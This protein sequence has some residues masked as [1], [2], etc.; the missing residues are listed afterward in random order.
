MAFSCCLHCT[1]SILV[2]AFLLATASSPYLWPLPDT[3]PPQLHD[4][5]CC[6]RPQDMPLVDGPQQRASGGL[7]PQPVMTGPP[8]GRPLPMPGSPSQPM[9]VNLDIPDHTRM[10]LRPGQLVLNL[11]KRPG[12]EGGSPGRRPDAG[13][14]LQHDDAGPLPP[15][16]L[17]NAAGIPVGQLPSNFMPI[18]K[19][20]AACLGSPVCVCGLTAELAGC[21][22]TWYAASVLFAVLAKPRACCGLSLR[23]LWEVSCMVSTCGMAH[24]SSAASHACCALYCCRQPRRAGQ[25]PR[26]RP[27]GRHPP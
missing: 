19:L 11:S 26:A 3:T 16:R 15:K 4:M 17:K 9:A 6:L 10:N 22:C 20:R 1:A 12:P 5:L 27:A 21:M 18:S 25:L 14:M 2:K 23:Q 24:F 7:H 8:L 13:L